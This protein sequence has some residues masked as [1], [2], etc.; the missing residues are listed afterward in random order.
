MKGNW[1]LINGL[2]NTP[3]KGSIYEVQDEFSS[4]LLH[5]N[6]KNSQKGSLGAISK[7]QI[8]KMRHHMMDEFG[9]W[10]PSNVQPH[11]KLQQQV[12]ISESA[13]SQLRLPPVHSRNSTAVSALA[14]TGA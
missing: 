2:Q 12:A 6:I 13:A 4:E 10:T 11:G 14:D 5:E 7:K 3:S 8:T 1:F 9:R